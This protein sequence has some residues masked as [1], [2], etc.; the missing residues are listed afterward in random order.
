MLAR[1]DYDKIYASMIKKYFDYGFHYS[2]ALIVFLMTLIFSTT[3]PIVVPFGCLFFYVKYYFDKYNLLFFYPAEFESQGNIGKIVFKFM[4]FAIVFF[5]IILSGLFYFLDDI[6]D[7]T[8]FIAF[9][10]IAFA[11][12]LY[13]I[14]NKL[15]TFHNYKSSIKLFEKIKEKNNFINKINNNNKNNIDFK[16]SKSDKINLYNNNIN[17]GNKTKFN[18]NITNKSNNNIINKDIEMNDLNLLN[19]SKSN[20]ELLLN[21]DIVQNNNKYIESFV[22]K[23]FLRLLNNGYLNSKESK[24]VFNKKESINNYNEFNELEIFNDYSDTKLRDSYNKYYIILK[25]AYMHPTQ[26]KLIDNPIF[27][28]SESFRYLKNITEENIELNE[29]IIGKDYND[30]SDLIIKLK[31]IKKNQINTDENE[32]LNNNILLEE[33]LDFKIY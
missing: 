7:S 1:T 22:R 2:F 23:S 26:K 12:V 24:S 25:E 11:I 8:T 31:Y 19:I 32:E 6:D 4:L 13:F 29:K 16:A 5:Q 3:I 18:I 15:F 30:Y 9:F 17:N 33:M 20:N 28:Y 14:S 21:N 10:Y 27:V